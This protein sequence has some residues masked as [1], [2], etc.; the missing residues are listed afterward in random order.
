M[1]C[2]LCGALRLIGRIPAFAPKEGETQ[3]ADRLD[4]WDYAETN[5]WQILN[6]DP[7][8]A[9]LSPIF[10]RS[11]ER[12]EA[13]FEGLKSLAERGSVWSMVLLGYCYL[14]GD[15]VGID[16]EA[17][18]TWFRKAADN[19]SQRALLIL[20]RRYWRRG[21]FT[22][23]QTLFTD[24]AEKGWPPAVFWLARCHLKRTRNR[25]GFREVR[26]HL[27]WAM[28]AGSPAAKLVLS[29]NLLRGRGGVRDIPLG[30]RLFRESVMWLVDEKAKD[31]ALKGEDQ[32]G[33]ERM[34]V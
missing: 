25:A 9:E 20:G 1:Q 2:I 4:A 14:Q 15:G 7:H 3:A 29:V 8:Q 21:W 30:F 17:A 18:D 23:G 5:D 12:S 31:R 28:A 34:P 19:G 26:P 33:G 24:S 22:M 32:D 13:R 16:Q 27:E 10:N 6:D 11:P